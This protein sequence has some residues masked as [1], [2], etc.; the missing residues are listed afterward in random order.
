[1][2]GLRPEERPGHR[3]R[4]PLA[5]DRDLQQIREIARRVLPRLDDLQPPLPRAGQRVDRVDRLRPHRH[6]QKPLDH[7]ARDRP[8]VGLVDLARVVDGERL[9]AAAGE[10]LREESAELRAEGQVRADDRERL[11]VEARGVDGVADD[12]FEQRGAHGVR[13]SRCRRFPAPRRCSRPG[14]G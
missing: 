14:A 4:L 1:M 2:R 12:A 7:R 13:R 11:G 3:G 5:A 9:G 10:R 8:R 6:F